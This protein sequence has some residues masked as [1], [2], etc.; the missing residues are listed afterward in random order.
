M[1]AL[2]FGNVSS[3]SHEHRLLC[4]S[5]RGHSSLFLLVLGGGKLDAPPLFALVVSD[6]RVQLGRILS[7]AELARLQLQLLSLRHYSNPSSACLPDSPEYCVGSLGKMPWGRWACGGLLSLF[8]FL[9][10]TL[11]WAL[12]ESPSKTVPSAMPF[13]PLVLLV[14]HATV[15]MAAPTAAAP[16]KVVVK[17]YGEAL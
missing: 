4:L 7:E 5:C 16:A 12:S 2:I 6:A 11:C 3:L 10:N 1:V 9:S 17:F 14:T 8:P 15:A 13:T